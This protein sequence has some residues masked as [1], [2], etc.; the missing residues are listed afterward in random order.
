MLK[1]E[2]FSEERHF[3]LRSGILGTL[4]VCPVCRDTEFSGSVHF[5][6]PNLHL[7]W[8]PRRSHNCGMKRLVHVRLRHGNIIFEPAGHRLPQG[9]NN[10]QSSVAIFDIIYNNTNRKQIVNLVELLVFRGHFLIYTV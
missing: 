7:S 9:M 1:F 10:S 5:V 4:F 8:F 6:S 3:I 2:D